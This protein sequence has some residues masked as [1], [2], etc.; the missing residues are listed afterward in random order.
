MER[1]QQLADLGAGLRA[2]RAK[3]AAD[4]PSPA[5][6][7]PAATFLGLAVIGVIV[8]A[9]FF[10]GSGSS[11]SDVSPGGAAGEWTLAVTGN[12]K[13]T[14][15]TVVGGDIDITLVVAN[16]GAA[17]NPATLIQIIGI[18]DYADI[19]TCEP[20]CRTTAL[21]RVA[22]VAAVDPGRSTVFTVHLIAKAVGAPHW[23]VCVYDDAHATNQVYCGEATTT[24]R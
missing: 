15:S 14:S 22:T 1:D 23:S 11:S 20:A 16:T 6:R 3:R 4:A 10:R 24:I 8:W 19:A 12:A 18:D 13:Y 2:L 5:K 7:S 21:G 17:A 9:V